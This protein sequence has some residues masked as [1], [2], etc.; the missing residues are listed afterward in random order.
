MRFRK[1]LYVGPSEPSLR[2]EG[3]HAGLAVGGTGVKSEGNVFSVS[4]AFHVDIER[5]RVHVDQ[6]EECGREYLAKGR[7]PDLCVRRLEV[8]RCLDAA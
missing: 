4:C 5:S 6:R 1:H 2:L 3:W 8:G 7:P